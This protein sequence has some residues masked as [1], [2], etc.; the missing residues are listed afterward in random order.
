MVKYRITTYN[1][2]KAQ[3]TVYVIKVNKQRITT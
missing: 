1:K 2:R 3:D